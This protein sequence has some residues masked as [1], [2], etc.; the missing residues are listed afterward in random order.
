MIERRRLA[1]SAGIA[2]LVFVVVAGTGA[3]RFQTVA[4]GYA[5]A[6]AAIALAALTNAIRDAQRREQSRFRAELTRRR[7]QPG[8]PTELIRVSRDL[9][10]ASTS[11]GHHHERLRPLLWSIAEAR[12]RRPRQELGEEAWEL[13][14]PDAPPPADRNGPGVPLRRIRAAVDALERL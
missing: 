12:S 2:T 3:L 13:V 14:R 6:L 11:A 7:E 4:A 9:M 1:V 8:R 10:L 5:L